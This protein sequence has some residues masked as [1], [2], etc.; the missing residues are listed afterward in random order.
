M[1][2]T[3][4][5]LSEN[6]DVTI[7][8]QKQEYIRHKFPCSRCHNYFKFPTDALHMLKFLSRRIAAY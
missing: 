2:N 7:Q 1:K 6:L 4:H 8:N 5:K 3:M